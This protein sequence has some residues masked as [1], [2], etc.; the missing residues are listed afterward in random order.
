MDAWK[1]EGREIEEVQCF[2]YLDF[3]FNRKDLIMK[4]IRFNYEELSRKERVAAKKLW[5]L[6]ERL[7]T[8]QIL[9]RWVLFN[10]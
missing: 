5:G 3:I 6:G 10:T 8:M 9:R 4:I 1:W 2:K 7:Q